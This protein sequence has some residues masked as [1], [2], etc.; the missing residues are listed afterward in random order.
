MTAQASRAGV[1]APGV[2]AA[3]A[4]SAGAARATDA[5]GR[6]GAERYRGAVPDASLPSSEPAAAED[7]PGGSALGP[8]LGRAIREARTARK[9]SMRALASASDISQP[10]LSQI[11]SGQSL[12]SISTLYRIANVLGISPAGL[13]PSEPEPGAVSLTRAADAA[14]VPIAETDGAG[15]MREIAA[16]PTRFSEHIVEPG[17][18]MGD[19]F[20]SDGEQTVY[21]LSVRTSRIGIP[22][23]AKNSAAAARNAAQVVPF[24]S[25]R[26]CA[27]ASREW[28]STA[29][30]TS[31][32]PSLTFRS[33]LP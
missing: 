1:T 10:F 15:R 21:A 7:S 28:S 5:G 9:L 4:T 22:W 14:W 16:V 32:N 23:R 33:R 18:H 31:S 2:T 19:W 6:I 27:N 11:E 26:I 13:L 30:W 17:E 20:R 8:S 12:P 25:G 24:S 29:T 3:E